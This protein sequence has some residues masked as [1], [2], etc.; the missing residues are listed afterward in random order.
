MPAQL[1]I[2]CLRLGAIGLPAADTR[3]HINSAAAHL[4]KTFTAIESLTINHEL[5]FAWETPLEDSIEWTVQGS[6][7]SN[8][9][10]NPAPPDV[11]K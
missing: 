10:C 9:L 7:A 3:D 11:A 4:L 2:N 1:S 5:D 6:C 8:G